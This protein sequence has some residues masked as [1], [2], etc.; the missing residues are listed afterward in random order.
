MSAFWALERR[1]KPVIIKTLSETRGGVFLQQL[2]RFSDR[3]AKVDPLK[4]VQ[5][6][7]QRARAFLKKSRQQS[8]KGNPT[9]LLW[10]K[11]K[12]KTLS[13]SFYRQL[14]PTNLLSNCDFIDEASVKE[15][16]SKFKG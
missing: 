9:R 13:F 7:Q 1:F 11:K 8:N 4:R 3:N 14:F 16:V 10:Q 12:R 6:K 5:A 2:L 15:S